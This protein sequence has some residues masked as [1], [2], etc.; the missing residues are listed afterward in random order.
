MKAFSPSVLRATVALIIGFVLVKWPDVAID[1]I[2]ITVGLLF[3]ILGVIGLIC[4]FADKE[5]IPN[6]EFPINSIG[7][8]L[9][10]LCLIIFPSFFANVVTVL[11]GLILILGGLQQLRSLFR[12]RKVTDVGIVFYIVSLMI[13]LSGVYT[14]VYP[15]EAL[16]T[17]LLIIGI[18]SLVY[19]VFELVHWF[20]FI[21]NYPG[22]NSTDSM[23]IK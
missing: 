6:L 15:S 8:A 2:L 10:G 1:Y 20:K 22:D 9:F 23:R 17:S 18:A 12:V 11:F 16:S 19:G 21:R 7:G 14:L 4:Y 13:L 5:K 3:L